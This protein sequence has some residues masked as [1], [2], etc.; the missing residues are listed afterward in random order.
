MPARVADGGRVAAAPRSGTRRQPCTPP[1]HSPAWAAFRVR[2]SWWLSGSR[3]LVSGWC[4]RR[5][6]LA[7]PVPGV[8]LKPTAV[9]ADRDDRRGFKLYRRIRRDLADRSCP[10]CSSP[11]APDRRCRQARFHCGC[12][13]G[14]TPGDPAGAG[15]VRISRLFRIVPN[16]R[17]RVG[18][19]QRREM[20][21]G[22]GAIPD[23]GPRPRDQRPAG[24]APVTLTLRPCRVAQ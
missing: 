11:P 19:S 15:F 21:A 17:G 13:P 23:R 8:A 18:G 24:A 7:E 12:G 16:D 10:A 6:N 5:S 20:H 22:W 9:C 4:A 14:D 1:R 3:V 2:R